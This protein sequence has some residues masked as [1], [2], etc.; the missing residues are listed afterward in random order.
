VAFDDKGD[1]LGKP[2]DLLT[3]FLAG[4]GQTQGRP[5]DVLVAQDG[6]LLVSDDVGNIVWRVA[7]GK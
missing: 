3:G 6:A 1:A 7:K 2:R 4:E 5:V